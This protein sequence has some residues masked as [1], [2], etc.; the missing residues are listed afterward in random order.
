M[1]AAVQEEGLARRLDRL[2]VGGQRQ[3]R[4]GTRR[5]PDKRVSL[6]HS[7]A[8]R[9]AA[10]EHNS[11]VAAGFSHVT[12]REGVFDGRLLPALRDSP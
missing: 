1:D 3:W 12:E 4:R 9:H 2:R 8:E 7:D 6:R 10:A 5:E 11:P